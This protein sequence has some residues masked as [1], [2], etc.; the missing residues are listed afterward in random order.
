LWENI[1]KLGH[2]ETKKDDA[3]SQCFPPHLWAAHVAELCYLAAALEGDRTTGARQEQLEVVSRE[4]CKV[5]LRHDLCKRH[6]THTHTHTHTQTHTH[7]I[8]T[9]SKRV[10]RIKRVAD[11][12]SI[13]IGVGIDEK[14]KLRPAM[15]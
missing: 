13:D 7:S 6:S 10:S 2:H 5:T 15:H 12:I 1:R 8:R 14:D 3:V 4:V 11:G 9:H